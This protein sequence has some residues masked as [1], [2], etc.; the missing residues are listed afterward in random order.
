MS[1]QWIMVMS[2]KKSNH[3]LKPHPYARYVKKL[4]LSLGLSISA[5]ARIAG[6]SPSY[7]SQMEKGLKGPPSHSMPNQKI[8]VYT[9]HKKDNTGDVGYAVYVFNI[10][11][12]MCGRLP[13]DCIKIYQHSPIKV[14]KAIRACK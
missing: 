7:W 10:L 13:D 11:E 1:G 14:I 12:S 9:Y 5:M 2:K 8:S 6:M 3:Q 4:R